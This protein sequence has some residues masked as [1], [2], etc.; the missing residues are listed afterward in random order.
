MLQLQLVVAIVLTVAV[1]CSAALFFWL[2]PPNRT[3]KIVLPATV[4]DDAFNQQLSDNTDPFL[5]TKPED[6]VDGT[7]VNEDSFWASVGYMNRPS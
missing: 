3:G 7:P 6:F 4:E 1:F 2:S 5:V